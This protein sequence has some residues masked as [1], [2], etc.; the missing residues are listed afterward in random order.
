MKGIYR[1]LIAATALASIAVG[2]P[3]LASGPTSEDLVNDA[4]TPDDVLT[5]GLGV[6]FH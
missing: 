4:S 3:G 2:A 6:D 5:Y 1:K